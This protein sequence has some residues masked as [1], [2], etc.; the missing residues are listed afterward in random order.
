MD[1]GLCNELCLSTFSFFSFVHSLRVDLLWCEFEH[2]HWI[3]LII[4]NHTLTVLKLY[5]NRIDTFQSSSRNI[6]SHEKKSLTLI[7]SPRLSVRFI[8]L[9]TLDVEMP[10]IAIA[11]NR[12]PADTQ[13][14]DA[15][16]T[17]HYRS[18][19][20]TIRMYGQKSAQRKSCNTLFSMLTNPLS[21]LDAWLRAVFA[22]NGGK[23]SIQNQYTHSID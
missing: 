2:H 4:I 17:L 22:F 18:D 15:I 20:F 12:I 3:S 16:Q 13:L 19:R 11:M 14:L 21:R 23:W 9:V 7:F 6:A 1:F 8:S 5:C 10:W